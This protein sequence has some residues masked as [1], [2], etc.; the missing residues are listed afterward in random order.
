M[1]HG[2][3][4]VVERSILEINSTA[5]LYRHTQTGARLLSIA[6]D[7]EN[8]VFGITF[9]TPPAD[10]TGVA[11]IMEHS[12][13]CGSRR[14]PAKQP[15]IELGKGSLATFLNA[16]TYPDKTCY[17][18]ASQ[19]RPDFYNLINVYLDAVFHPLILE[20]TLQ[21]EGWHYELDDPAAPLSLKGVVFNEMKGAYSSPDEVLQEKSRTSL[22]PDNVYRLDSGGDPAA[23][24]D[25]TY[26]Q[27]RAF[28]AT[29]YHPA[30]AYIYFYGDDPE[31]ERLHLIGTWLA[32][33]DYQDV[34]SQIP[35]QAKF[36]QPKRIIVPYDSGDASDARYSIA[37]NW[38]LPEGT[39]V[40]TSL[41]LSIL[42]HILIATPA[43]PLRKA[44]IDSGLG[45]D[46][47]GGHEDQLRQTIFSA[48]LKGVRCEHVEKAERL[49]FDTL[50]RLA[51]A[52]LDPETV[53]A[54]LNTVEF[55]LREK[56]TG[57]F[58]R[59]LAMM[60]NALATWLYDG[61]PIAALAF[62]QPLNAIKAKAANDHY[63]ES[64]LVD[65]LV[66]NA[67]RTT[68][69]LEPD[70][71]EGQRREAA[72]KGRLAKTK[73]AMSEA[74]L[75]KVIDDFAELKR[76]QQTPDSPEALATIPALQLTDLDRRIKTIPIETLRQPG[77]PI[78]YHDLPQANGIVYLDLGFDLHSLPQ[79][80]LPYA[81]LFG[82]LLIE[83]G[84]EREDFVKLTQRIGR[85]TGGLRPTTFTS[86]LHRADTCPRLR[87]T[88]PLAG[89]WRGGQQCQ[90]RSTAY[91][92]MRGK[93]TIGQAPALLDILRDIL[94]TVRL[95]N[96]ARFRQIV[97]KSKA[98]ME[99][100][101]APGGT[102]VVNQRLRA[103]FDEA[104]WAAEQIEGV[105]QLFFLRT[106][107][108]AI[109]N[110]WPTVLSKLEA[111]RQRLVNRS[112][113]V[114][115]VTLDSGHWAAFRP[116]L[117]SFVE[118][119]PGAA[120]TAETWQPE[121]AAHAEGLT[122]PAQVNYVGKG[123]DLYRLGYN[124]HGSSLVISNYLNTTW[125]WEKVR[126]QGG[127][128]GG[129]SLFDIHSG[130]FTFLSW[131]D[132]NVLATIDTYD[133]AEKF[134]RD[135]DLSDAELT[136]AI[137]GAIGELDAYWLP[138]AK[139][140]TSM[141]RHLIGYTDARRQQF[142]DEVLST[143]ARDFK[144]FADALASVKEHGVVVV[145]GSQAAIE[146]ANAERQHWLKVTKVL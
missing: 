2:F 56:N 40:E 97:L 95:D 3:E 27:F 60:L 18:V 67:H 74:E 100:G 135:L 79:E 37:V 106:L 71:E 48:G 139:G 66:N 9:R 146:Q 5:R 131:R 19:N 123:A 34:R 72:E 134:L 145:L 104:D 84:T 80:L 51:R 105:S 132:P 6:N 39:D 129:A 57:S 98:G 64:L 119:L 29:Y 136:K 140:F 78:L 85:A 108:A 118:S 11:H 10:S 8:K 49:I 22:F 45:E 87:A 68:V 93:A 77:T 54:S 112:T 14:Y 28:H 128:Y 33:F 116:R 75:Q 46:V 127:A 59:G 117:E 31:P 126:Q 32:D 81:G 130:A 103:C 83:M 82:R 101:L 62:E 4:L 144:L 38:L 16:F 41:G 1:N 96:R 86:S 61:D 120:V 111:V 124:L 7:D 44:L 26:T 102:T 91:L 52:G 121:F 65:H 122:I 143:T 47:M 114:A 20:H 42:S 53:A 35:L 63:F 36:S 125:M 17:P 138:D 94:L 90:G 99:A 73:A 89:V 142:R 141:T 58:P 70:R 88:R 13:L 21:Q 137:I 69:I 92:F 113:M 25:L 12:V 43:S 76:R 133:A 109:E 24:P 107:A 110:D 55:R 15:F 115:N 30:N 50:N 23:I